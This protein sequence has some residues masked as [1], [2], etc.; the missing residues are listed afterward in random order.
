MIEACAGGMPS[1][2]RPSSRPTAHNVES[3]EVRYIEEES[4]KVYVGNICES[5]KILQT[6]RDSTYQTSSQG[7]AELEIKEGHY[8]D[9]CYE[10]VS[11][12]GPSTSREKE[13]ILIVVEINKN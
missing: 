1:F 12:L 3:E 5:R 4:K 2:C 9:L 6:C 8:V 13:T 11:F 10:K 7:V